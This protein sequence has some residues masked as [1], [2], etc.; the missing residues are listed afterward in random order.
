MSVVAFPL[1]TFA[2]RSKGLV[3][4]D[5]REDYSSCGFALEGFAARGWPFSLPAQSQCNYVGIGL[6]FSKYIIVSTYMK[7]TGRIIHCH[8]RND[9]AKECSTHGSSCPAEVQVSAFTLFGRLDI[10]EENKKSMID[11]IVLNRSMAGST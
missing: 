8:W 4:S 6:Y 5:V 2:F 7:G 3:K 10:Q 1:Y 11:T 9:K